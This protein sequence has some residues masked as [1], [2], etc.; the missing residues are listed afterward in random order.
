VDLDVEEASALDMSVALL[1]VLV[2]LDAWMVT[3]TK[4]GAGSSAMRAEPVK[5]SNAP[6]TFDTIA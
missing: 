6:R 5:L 3:F 2:R 1:V 4:D